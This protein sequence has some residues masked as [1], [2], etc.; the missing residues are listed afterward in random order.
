MTGTP[1]QAGEA[2][3]GQGDRAARSGD[4]CAWTADALS[5]GRER[6]S[7]TH[8]KRRAKHREEQTHL[9][10][11]VGPTKQTQKNQGVD[12]GSAGCLL[13]YGGLERDIQCS[14][15]LPRGAGCFRSV[16][17]EPAPGSCQMLLG[18]E[19]RAVR[20]LALLCSGWGVCGDGGSQ[21]GLRSSEHG[22]KE[23]SLGQVGATA[24]ELGLKK[25]VYGEGRARAGEGGYVRG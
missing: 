21:G 1:A 10:T 8:A 7:N 19:A 12:L 15:G 25:D 2:G 5:Q 4:G 17:R 11:T 16:Q 13:V 18:G 23:A 22:Q 24:Q 6:V 3:T 9:H 20:W 14:T